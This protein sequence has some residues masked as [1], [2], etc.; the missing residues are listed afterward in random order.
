MSGVTYRVVLEGT[1]AADRQRA[2]VIDELASLFKAP[3]SKIAPLLS[4]EPVT[5][6]R[7]LTLAA[8]AAYHAAIERTGAKCRVQP[9]DQSQPEAPSAPAQTT[10]QADPVPSLANTASAPQA[11]TTSAPN[12][13]WARIF[14]MFDR[15]GGATWE[16]YKHLPPDDA[17]HVVFHWP[18]LVL[19]V[20]WY[21]AKRM[22]WRGLALLCW[23]VL[24]FEVVQLVLGVLG[25]RGMPDSM[26][27]AGGVVF[28]AFAR[29]DYYR[30]WRGIRTRWTGA[31]I[32]AGALSISLLATV[33]LDGDSLGSAAGTSGL[34]STTP[35]LAFLESPLDFD[36]VAGSVNAKTPSVQTFFKGAL[37]P[38]A[39]TSW[40]R[41]DDNTYVFTATS[42]DDVTRER[43]TIDFVL[44]KHR[45]APNM[46]EV[47]SATR[48]FFDGN[49]VAGYDALQLK[50]ILASAYAS[51]AQT[52][53]PKS[54]SPPPARPDTPR[55]TR[56]PEKAS[57][58]AT[59]PERTAQ[60]IEACVQN[61]LNAS[62]RSP[63][64]LVTADELAELSADCSNK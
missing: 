38:Q 25:L 6:K 13:Y 32:A 64:L 56:A 5:I 47:V 20:F 58:K 12:A 39:R 28:A 2:A 10:A 23:T 60:Q 7:G 50:M 51:R 57:A 17:K 62:A 35:P 18:A 36:N 33:W 41:I 55:L 21:A 26:Y 22:W 8:A 16:S 59:A 27:F 19:G 42:V 53:S 3:A 4:G 37:N 9:D 45:Y 14:A 1:L 54:T 63:D 15:V 61:K 11:A 30:H 24:A 40:R 49:E 48:A 52:A 29:A 43:H 34:L 31:A 44:M 46:P